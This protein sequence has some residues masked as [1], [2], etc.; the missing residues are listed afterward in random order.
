MSTTKNSLKADINEFLHQYRKAPH[1]ETG[2]CPSKLFLDRSIRTRLDLVRP[3][4]ISCRI[5][6]KQRAAFDSSFRVFSLGMFEWT[7]GFQ[8]LLLHVWEICTTKLITTRKT[9]NVMSIKFNNTTVT[10][11]TSPHYRDS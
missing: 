9:S 6:E 5:D 11:A 1:S 3:Q 7:I 4:D 2:E 8:E 10:K